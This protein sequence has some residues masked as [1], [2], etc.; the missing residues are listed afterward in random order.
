MGASREARELQAATAQGLWRGWMA[1]L[2]PWWMSH[3]P[4]LLISSIADLDLFLLLPGFP[5]GGSLSEYV[6]LSLDTAHRPLRSAKGG[7]R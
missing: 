6:E 2:V 5:Q 4:V 7:A 3:V 1:A